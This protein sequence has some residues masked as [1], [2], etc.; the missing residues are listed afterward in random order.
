MPN[1]MFSAQHKNDAS[2]SRPI[3][4]V[5]IVEYNMKSLSKAQEARIKRVCIDF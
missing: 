1:K 2:M 3:Q 5:N 4:H